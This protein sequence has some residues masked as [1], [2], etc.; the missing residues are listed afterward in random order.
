MQV[1]FIGRFHAW[2]TAFGYSQFCFSQLLVAAI[3]LH[4]CFRQ[5]S[6]G[7][8]LPWVRTAFKYHF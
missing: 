6:G 5:I 7:E 1:T 2:F 3:N 8:V 4:S